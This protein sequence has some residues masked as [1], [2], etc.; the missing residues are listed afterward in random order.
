MEWRNY[1]NFRDYLN[2]YP[3]IAKQYENVKIGLVEKLGSMRKQR[4]F[5]K[6]CVNLQ[7]GIE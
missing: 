5:L 1:I 4:D 7:D 2:T 6:S 3:E